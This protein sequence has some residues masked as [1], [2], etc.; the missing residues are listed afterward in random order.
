PDAF[1]GHLRGDDFFASLGAKDE[2]GAIAT[3]LGASARFARDVSSF[4]SPEDRAAGWILGADREGRERR[5]GLL[6]V[7]VGIVILRA[8]AHLDAE[9][10]SLALAELKKAAKSSSDRWALRAIGG[11]KDEPPA[12]RRF[13][14][15]A[16]GER[17]D[18]ALALP[19]L[20]PRPIVA[21]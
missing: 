4:Y 16:D 19:I 2:E 15:R 11:R 7:S 9:G 20:I 14:S 8:G 10:L 17:A 6:T 3:L 5:M 12:M 21:C 1:V 18:E 13:E